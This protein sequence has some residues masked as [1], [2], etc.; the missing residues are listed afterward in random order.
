MPTVPTRGP[1]ASGPARPAAV[2][3]NP[4]HRRLW[5]LLKLLVVPVAVVCLP[6]LFVS[7]FFGP[8]PAAPPAAAPPDAAFSTLRESLERAA[9][10]RLPEGTP[11]FGA[12]FE[13]LSVPCPPTEADA[14][15]AFLREL[16]TFC[17]G[18]A[19]DQ[20]DDPA[21]R[22]LLVDLPEDSL[23]RF[24]QGAAANPSTPPT[25]V[26][27]NPPTGGNARVFLRVTLTAPTAP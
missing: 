24:R 13:D 26:A 5:L 4:P 20:A 6:S 18:T 17:G 16:A 11:T 8:R 14:R 10:E 2:G 19:T 27:T 7:Y 3:P 23:P 22:H 12:R 25:G 9:R 1:V 15:L 21:G